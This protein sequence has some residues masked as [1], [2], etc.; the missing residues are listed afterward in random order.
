LLDYYSEN[1]IYNPEHNFKNLNFNLLK[2]E[3]NSVLPQDWEIKTSLQ[4]AINDM[5]A[6]KF[7][8]VVEM[9]VGKSRELNYVINSSIKKNGCHIELSKT[10]CQNI[11]QVTNSMLPFI[12]LDLAEQKCDPKNI[13]E[14]DIHILLSCINA[15]GQQLQNSIKD[16]AKE[17]PQP[18]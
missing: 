7:V 16:K 8:K 4:G 1:D 13:T 9:G 17:S 11:A 10:T 6:E 15:L 18:E 14:S 12:S 3:E 5:V 2:D